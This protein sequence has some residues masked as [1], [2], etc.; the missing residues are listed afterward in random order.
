MTDLILFSHFLYNYFNYQVF[1]SK[2]LYLKSK[3]YHIQGCHYML[4]IS[5]GPSLSWSYGSWIYYYLCNQCLSPL[6]LWV[7][8]P[9]VAR[10]TQYNIMWLTAVLSFSLGTPVSSTN[11][12]D[13]HVMTDILLKVAL[14]TIPLTLNYFIPIN[15][16]AHI[17]MLSIFIWF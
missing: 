1:L 10:F 17:L 2:L 5:D 15:I 14:N 11:K 6:T 3:N 4:H 7:G 13:H 16:N 12:A 9:L 8:I